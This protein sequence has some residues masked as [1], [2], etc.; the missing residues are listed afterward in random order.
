V[1][2]FPLDRIV[3]TVAILI[4]KTAG[5]NIMHSVFQLRMNSGNRIGFLSH[6]VDSYAVGRDGLDGSSLSLTS[7]D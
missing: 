3:T 2:I 7:S 4:N 1:T 5:S 6:D